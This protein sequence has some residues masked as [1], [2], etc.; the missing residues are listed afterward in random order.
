M[1]VSDHFCA[2]VFDNSLAPGN[3][4]QESIVCTAYTMRRDSNGPHNKY[5][6]ISTVLG[7]DGELD[8]DKSER[9][10]LYLSFFSTEQ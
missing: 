2:G 1:Y 5:C 7:E 3:V 9:R 8:C 4:E 10:V 6:V